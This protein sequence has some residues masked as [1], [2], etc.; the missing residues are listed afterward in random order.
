VSR[1]DVWFKTSVVRSLMYSKF[2]DVM[3][4]E[5]HFH[6][7]SDE[8][9]VARQPVP[10]SHARRELATCLV[11]SSCPLRRAE[12]RS[13]AQDAGWETMVCDDADSARLAVRRYRFQ[14]AWVDTDSFDDAADGEEICQGLAWMDHVLLAVCG[15]EGDVQEEIWARQLGVWLYLP[16]LPIGQGAEIQMLCEQ[17]LLLASRLQA[18]C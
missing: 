16:G 12:L 2:R 1:H 4:N 8:G 3:G 17:G 10:S 11:V 6:T 15:R 5:Y 13:A 18:A 14:M 9:G 7:H